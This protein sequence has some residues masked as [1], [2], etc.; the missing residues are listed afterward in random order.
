MPA[1]MIVHATL[2]DRKQFIAGYAPAAA[3]LVEQFGGRYVLRATGAALANAV[4][5]KDVMSNRNACFAYC[6]R[7]TYTN[8]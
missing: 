7:I 1:Y 8:E 3:A 2:T 5:S 4:I 6:M